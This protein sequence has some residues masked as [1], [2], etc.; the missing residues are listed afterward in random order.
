MPNNAFVLFR[1]LT[2]INSV[3]YITYR[4]R[5]LSSPIIPDFPCGGGQFAPH[6]SLF[7]MRIQWLAA[8]PVHMPDRATAAGGW[9]A[10]PPDRPPWGHPDII[11]V[12]TWR[13]TGARNNGLGAWKQFPAPC[14][15]S[16]AN[17]WTRKG[18][19]SR[20]R[21]GASPRSP[22]DRALPSRS[23]AVNGGAVSAIAHHPG[24]AGTAEGGRVMAPQTRLC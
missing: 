4:T 15:S 19:S 24:R 12:D 22:A 16:G 14:T 5:I 1:S 10:G 23:P 11:L 9:T 13:D 6:P 17:T 7:A 20:P 3:F 18:P 2:V 21:D 8:F